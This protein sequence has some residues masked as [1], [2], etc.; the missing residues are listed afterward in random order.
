MKYHNAKGN[1]CIDIISQGYPVDIVLKLKFYVSAA[2]KKSS[3]FGHR[4]G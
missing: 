1:N 2:H 3:V 4:K